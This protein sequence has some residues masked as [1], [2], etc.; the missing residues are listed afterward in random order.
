VSRATQETSDAGAGLLKVLVP[1]AILAA[2][3]FGAWKLFLSEP[4]KE[5]AQQ[6]S[7]MASDAAGAVSDTAERITVQ[8]PA[9][10]ALD[11]DA[12]NKR[13]GT[14]FGDL[15]KSVSE[16]TDVA[17][18]RAAIPQFTKLQEQFQVDGLAK[19]PAEQM[20]LLGKT[21]SPML[22]KLQSALE[23]AYRIPG[24][25]AILEPAVLGL[26]DKVSVF[27]KTG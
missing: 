22:E 12:I 27:T 5:I 24:V 3:G 13:M 15:T 19:M 26:T 10:P 17:S 11:F 20:S 18:A 1:L 7:T 9:V 14:S 6:T 16:I 4:A 25:K 8:K 23:V 2:L 21:L